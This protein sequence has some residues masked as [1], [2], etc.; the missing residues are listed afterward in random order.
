MQTATKPALT[1]EAL[2]QEFDRLTRAEARVKEARERDREE[3]SLDSGA[4]LMDCITTAETQ[5]RW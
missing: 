3:E 2:G 4:N 1:I 5:A